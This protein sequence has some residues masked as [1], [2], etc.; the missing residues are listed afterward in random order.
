MKRTLV[1]L[2]ALMGLGG[3]S[4]L[5]QNTFIGG[6]PLPMVVRTQVVYSPFVGVPQVVA[7][8]VVV[9]TPVMLPAPVVVRSPIVYPAPVYAAPIYSTSAYSTPVYAAP[10]VVGS[11]AFVRGRVYY[12]GEP[13]RNT[14]KAVW[15]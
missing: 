7:A 3:S 1:V 11:P 15:P 13:V 6:A 12:R 4:A 10:V 9:S 2:L 14:L 5:A 8:P